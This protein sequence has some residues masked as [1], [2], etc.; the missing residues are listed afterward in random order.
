MSDEISLPYDIAEMICQM[1]GVCFS[2]G[3]GPNTEKLMLWI[4]E[5]YP[6]LRNEYDYMPWPIE[7]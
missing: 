1:E 2:E 5:T 6:D 4:Q 7:R 3:L